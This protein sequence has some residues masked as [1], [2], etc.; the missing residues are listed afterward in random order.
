MS[1]FN[2]CDDC[3]FEVIEKAKDE[4]VSSTNIEDSPDEMAVID[5]FLFR[6]WQMG[7][8]DA[9]DKVRELRVENWKLRELVGE[10]W[11]LLELTGNDD[12]YAEIC[13]NGEVVRTIDADELLGKMGELGIHHDG[14]KMPQDDGK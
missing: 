1:V 5:T 14:C 13:H 2:N 6:C 9:K 12:L 11:E 10:L 4:L 8:L 3:M 7:W